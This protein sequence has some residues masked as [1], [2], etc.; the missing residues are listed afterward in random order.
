MILPFSY[1]RPLMP[2]EIEA[3]M[4]LENPQ[5]MVARLKACGAT[6]GGEFMEINSFYDTEDRKLLAADEGLRVRVSRDLGSG[7]MR[8][9]LTYK[10]RNRFG[11]LKSREEIEVGI[12]SAEEIDRMLGRL[13]YARCL[14][15]EKRRQSWKLGECKVELDEVPHLGAFIE[16][17]GPS[18]E[19]IM[20]VRERLGLSNQPLIKSSYVALLTGYLQERGQPIAEIVFPGSTEPQVAQAG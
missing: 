2:V 1:A 5:V 6:M 17:E 9:V 7:E 14:S 10:G 8:C 16:I 19:V 18:E 13:G 11:P 12:S 15:F 20:G 3:K 4:K